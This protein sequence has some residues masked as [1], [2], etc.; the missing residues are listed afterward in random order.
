MTASNISK[1]IQDDEND[2]NS[3][4]CCNYAQLRVDLV[5]DIVIDKNALYDSCVHR[6][7][8]L[9]RVVFPARRLRII[10]TS[11]RI[12]GCVFSLLIRFLLI[13]VLQSSVI[14]MDILDI[15]V[16]A[17]MNYV[18][19]VRVHEGRRR[20]KWDTPEADPKRNE[21][22]KKLNKFNWASGLFIMSMCLRVCV[23]VCV[24][25]RHTH[26]HIAWMRAAT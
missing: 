3:V 7:R 6:M 18:V 23:C 17:S 16:F 5:A 19:I 2:I 12:N 22:K 11:I 8:T 14:C 10:W 15:S 24:W 20:V 21:K 9:L 4:F 13:L 1:K 26:T 25:F